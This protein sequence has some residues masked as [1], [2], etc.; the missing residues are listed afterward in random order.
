MERE[1]SNDN[2]SLLVNNETTGVVRERNVKFVS[3]LLTYITSHPSTLISM[4]RAD[5]YILRLFAV[6]IHLWQK[7]VCI[8]SEYMDK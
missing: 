2:W 6:Y 7:C 5:N 1:M 8:S 4:I 3:Q